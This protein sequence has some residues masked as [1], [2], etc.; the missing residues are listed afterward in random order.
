MKDVCI[1]IPTLNEAETIGEIIADFKREGFDNIF[2]IDGNSTDSTRDIAER[3]GVK[4]EIQRGKGKGTAVRQAF[5]LIDRIA[6]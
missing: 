3:A 4:V 5:E 6:K 1:L 2:V